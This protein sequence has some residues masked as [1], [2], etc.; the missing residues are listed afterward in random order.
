ALESDPVVKLLE[1]AAYREMLIRARVNDAARA[2]MLSHAMGSDLENLA[3]LLGVTRL[4]DGGQPELDDRLRL[5]AQMALEGAIVAGSYGSYVFHALSASN[6]VKDVVVDSPSPG[7]VRVAVLSAEA[8][9]IPGSFI[10][11]DKLWVTIMSTF[12]AA[13]SD[14][15]LANIVDAYLSAGTRRPLTDSVQVEPVNTV[16]FDVD[17]TLHVY[18]GPSY[19]QILSM[20]QA[21]VESYI[22][23]H[24]K[25]G[26]DITLSGLYAALHQ[27]GGV[28]KVVLASP[29]ADITIASRQASHC[30]SITLRIEIAAD[31]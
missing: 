11:A 23:E 10:R 29:L 4:T 7:V 19:A 22:K 27:P 21:A 13:I 8:D 5:R 9:G 18:P 1:L 30:S 14:S 25:I 26:W 24:A 16:P 12:G 15:E 20:A 2:C 31:V 17:A 28:K 3:A 6:Y